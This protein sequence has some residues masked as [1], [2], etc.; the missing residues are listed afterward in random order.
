MKNICFITS[1]NLP[2]GGGTGSDGEGCLCGTYSIFLF[3]KTDF[4]PLF[5]VCEVITL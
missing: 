3:I 5:F 4:P 2:E 1:P